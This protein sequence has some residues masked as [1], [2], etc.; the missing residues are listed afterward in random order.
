MPSEFVRRAAF[1]VSAAAAFACKRPEQSTPPPAVVATY[2]VGTTATT[3]PDGSQPY[4]PAKTIA[5]RRTVD[6]AQGSIEEL[7]VHPGEQFV[8]LLQRRPGDAA[9]FAASD[10]AGGFTGTVTF[11]GPEWAWTAWTY[12]IAMTDGSGE[13]QGTGR[14]GERSLDTDK[15]FVGPDGQPR[16]RIAEHLE[17]VDEPTYASARDGLLAS[18]P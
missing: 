4:G 7:V 6:P 8:T 16:A 2:Y 9:V 14:L 3:S 12:D 18:A 10:R 11:T 5:V 17:Q 13:L 15:L 1:V